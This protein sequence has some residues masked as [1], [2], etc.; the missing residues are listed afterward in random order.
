MGVGMGAAQQAGERKAAGSGDY[1]PMIFWKDD[2]AGEGKQYKR[3]V[4]FLSDD[5]ITCGLYEFVKGG[6][7][8]KGR[9]FIAP[10]TLVDDQGKPLFEELIGEKDYFLENNVMLPT[11]KGDLKPAKDRVAERTLGLVILREEVMVDRNGRKV[12]DVRDLIEKRKWTD[13]ENNEH[14]EEGPVFGVV[15]QG[16]KNFWSTLAGYYNKFG[17]ICDRDYEI[18]RKGNDKDTTY[19]IIRL[20]EVEGL[21]TPEKV[22]AHYKPRLTLKDWIIPKARYSAAEDWLKGTGTKSESSGGSDEGAS[23][24]AA[25]EESSGSEEVRAP[26]GSSVT[27]SLRSELE[28]YK[29]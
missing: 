7:D 10:G 9:D 26:S 5:V 27:D 12:P 13:K 24:S 16:Y 20:D 23:S 8:G 11:Y 1:L 21:E 22:A 3:I 2:R 28:A 17:T 19:S 25:R 4:R 6:P 15:K 14:E 29:A 18:T